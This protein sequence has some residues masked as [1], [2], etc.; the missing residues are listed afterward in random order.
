MD[1]AAAESPD[2]F[3]QVHNPFA[4][5]AA[6]KSRVLLL[7][8]FGPLPKTPAVRLESVS[9]DQPAVGVSAGPVHVER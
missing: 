3:R 5:L 2:C 6:G 4:A 7:D 8:W 9:V 1:A